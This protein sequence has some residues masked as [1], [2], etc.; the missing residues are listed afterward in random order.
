MSHSTAIKKQS[1]DFKKTLSVNRSVNSAPRTTINPHRHPE[2]AKG[3]CHKG[4]MS[5]S[6]GT[7]LKKCQV[8]K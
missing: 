7:V 3:V 8:P 2:I 6:K 5:L 4:L 1:S